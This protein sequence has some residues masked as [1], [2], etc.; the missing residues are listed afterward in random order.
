MH[1]E[2]IRRRGA[3]QNTDPELFFPER[4]QIVPAAVQ[5]MCDRCTVNVECLLWAVQK[6]ENGFWA[7]TTDRQ[8]RVMRRPR[9]RAKCP[10]CESDSLRSGQ[11]SQLCTSCGMSWATP[12]EPARQVAC[13]A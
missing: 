13:A 12:A 9:H 2:T 6:R 4:G 7:G 11:R 8:R 1:L 10:V 3:C 5:A